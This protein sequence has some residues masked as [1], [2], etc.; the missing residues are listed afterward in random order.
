MFDREFSSMEEIDK[1]YADH[2]ESLRLSGVPFDEKG[3]VEEWVQ[4][5]NN[6]NEKSTLPPW[7]SH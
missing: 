1:V 7:L 5:L 4:A 6:F 2:I 3:I